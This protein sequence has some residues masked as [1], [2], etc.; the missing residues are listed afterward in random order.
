MNGEM[1]SMKNNKVTNLIKL[2]CGEKIIS[3]KCVF[4]TNKDSLVNI[5][6]YK[7]KIVAKRFIQKEIIDYTNIF[8]LIS[9]KY[10]S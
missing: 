5:K 3:C 6:R 8:S 7:T 9:K 1:S 4:K 10:S 2:H